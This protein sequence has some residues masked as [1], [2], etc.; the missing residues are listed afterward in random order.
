MTVGC[1]LQFRMAW[2]ALV[3]SASLLLLV[4]AVDYEFSIVENTG[5]NQLV[6]QIQVPADP[7]DFR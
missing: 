7:T 3:I 4:Q 2:V 5:N 1:K 6:G